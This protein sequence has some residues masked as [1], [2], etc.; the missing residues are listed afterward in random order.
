MKEVS[1]NLEILTTYI[2]S[3]KDVL[4]K[5]S[6]PYHFSGSF[7]NRSKMTPK[8]LLI[9]SAIPAGAPIR[10]TLSMKIVLPK[11]YQLIAVSARNRRK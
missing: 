11:H 7:C 2:G 4:V 5:I 1:Y 8:K 6:E 10:P 3:V 9:L